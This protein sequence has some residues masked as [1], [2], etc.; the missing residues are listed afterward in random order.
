ML[1]FV[2][3][4]PDKADEYLSD[5]MTEELLNALVKAKD[6]RVPGRSSSFAFKGKTGADLYHQVGDQL[7]VSAVLEGSVR[8]AGDKLRVTAKLV[9]VANGFSL[10]SE[11]YDRDMT[12]IFAVQS[13]IAAR[14]AEALKV[15]LLGAAAQPKKPTQ[16]IE[17][18]ELYLQ[19]R[20]LWNRRTEAS[21]T[22]AIDY[23]NRAIALDPGYALAYA[24][25]A[26]CYAILSDYGGVPPR[27]TVP[28]ARAAALKAI[29]LDGTLGEPHA[30]LGDTES[31]FDWDWSGAEAEFRRAID[32]NP[33]YATTHHWFGIALDAQNRLGEA[34][35]EFQLAQDLDPLSPINTQSLADALFRIGKEELAIQILQKQIALDPGYAGT[36]EQLGICLIWQGK[37]SEAILELEKAHE[38]YGNAA[39]WGDCGF[40]YARSGRASDAQQVL[41]QLFQLQQGGENVMMEIALVCHGLGDD[42]RALDYLEKAAE[43]RATGLLYLACSPFWKDLRPHPRAQAILRKMHLVK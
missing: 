38:L 33:T 7:H 39:G 28:K 4:S 31:C 6:L 41:D 23:F 17:A 36:H 8:K 5:G 30:A 15:R 32:L 9:N 18:Y 13:D 11:E 10:W 27:E 25:L 14:V 37:P 24:G 22:Q 40:A 34:V 12:N 20:L 3:F 29:E 21:F 19:G 2:N 35:T 1:P 26:D 16:S 42:T 43:A